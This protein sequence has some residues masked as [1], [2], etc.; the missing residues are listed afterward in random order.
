M[1]RK[2]LAYRIIR[3]L[4][5]KPGWYLVNHVW[6]GTEIRHFEKKR[7]FRNF[8]GH[9]IGEGTTVVGPLWCT[10]RLAVGKNCWIENK[11]LVNEN[12]TVTIGD[13]CDIAPEVAF[14]TGGHKIG[15]AHKRAGKG[16]KFNIEVGNG[17]W[18]GARSTILGGVHVGDSRVIAAC[19]N[20][21]YR[22]IHWLAAYRQESFGS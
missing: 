20:K 4:I 7:K 19:V 3:R 14:Q 15:S 13:C 22:R 12:G 17:C 16:V 18:L 10:G 8:L 1:N 21:L 2:G 11:L 6:C 5:S 9:Q